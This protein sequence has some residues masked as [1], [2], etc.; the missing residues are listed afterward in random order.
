MG[1]GFWS[2]VLVLSCWLTL[3]VGA[4]EPSPA[5]A[6]KIRTGFYMDKVRSAVSV[7]R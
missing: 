5:P 1:R 3:G 7:R 2:L 4:S 6:K